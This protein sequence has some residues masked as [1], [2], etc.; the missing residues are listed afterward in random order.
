MILSAPFPFFGGKSRAAHLVW[1]RFGDVP[2]YVEPFA[3]SLAVLLRRP[4]W[5]ESERRTET[6]NDL[7]GTVTNFWRATQRDPEAVAAA[8]DNPVHELDLNARH[9]ACNERLTDETGID[10][11]NLERAKAR[12][13]LPFSAKLEQDPD[14]YDATLAGWWAWGLSSWIGDSWCR[15]KWDRRPHLGDAG[16]GVNRKRPHL[17]NAGKGVNRQVPYLGDAGMGECERRRDFLVSWFE[18]LRDR[19]RDV[20]ICCG[21]FERVLGPGAAW[22]RCAILLDPPYAESTGVERVYAHH[23]NDAS[24]RTREWAIANGGNTKL[25]ICLCGYEG[26]HTMPETWECVHWEARGGY[27]NGRRDKSN[28]NKER[29]RLWFSPGCRKSHC[30]Y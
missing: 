2:N 22:G 6:I 27:G 14:F 16:K 13:I 20:R 19:L 29:E 12:G 17:G 24:R 25:R 8:A 18:A 30:L 3:G 15:P 5:P 28:Q 7:D 11:D 10:P 21:D 23:G 9:I 1:P 4:P 26:E